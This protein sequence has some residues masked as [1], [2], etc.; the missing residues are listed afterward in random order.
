MNDGAI[1]RMNVL[2]ARLCGYLWPAFAATGL[3]NLV[4]FFFSGLRGV[5]GT[6]LFLVFGLI[7]ALIV[8]LRLQLSCKAEEENLGQKAGPPLSQSL[9]GGDGQDVEPF[10]AQA[11]QRRFEKVAIP[12]MAPL[13]MIVETAAAIWLFNQLF[14][15]APDPV[16]ML[17]TAGMMA[18]QAFGFFLSGKYLQSLAK[19]PAHRLLREPAVALLVACGLSLLVMLTSVAAHAGFPMADQIGGLLTALLLTLLAVEHA[20]RSLGQLY[21][22]HRRPSY[23]PYASSLLHRLSQPA[24]WFA[25]VTDTLDYQF[26]FQLS[27]TRSWALLSRA[28][29]PFIA[30]QMTLLYALS[31]FVFL[32]PGERGFRE[33]LGRPQLADQPLASG[34]HL[35]WPWPFERIRRFPAMRVQRLRI[36]VYTDSDEDPDVILWTQPHFQR[37]LHWLVPGKQDDEAES[38]ARGVPVSLLSIYMVVDY[39]ISDL[40]SYAYRFTNPRQTLKQLAESSLMR[41]VGKRDLDEL[42]SHGRREAAQAVHDHLRETVE[43]LDMGISIDFVGLADIHPPLEVADAFQSVVGAFEERQAMILMAEAYRNRLLPQAEADAASLRSEARAYLAARS[44]AAEAE[45]QRFEQR[46][47]VHRAAPNSYLSDYRLR[48]LELILPDIRKFVITPE[49]H[50]EVVEWKYE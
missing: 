5:L 10:S 32:E 35:K 17:P 22:V 29:L 37:E 36:G 3:L 44:L 40:E 33:I 19:H 24:A 15:P 30:L 50:R 48:A 8:R 45:A 16:A 49:T 39:R 1:H 7:T 9:F 42:L 2:P 27:K 18:G 14:A 11:A 21:R 23:I 20:I 34:L 38:E 31:C 6:A 46:L 12:L 13:L 28:V 25:P 41:E 47:K 4:M 43:R 26:G